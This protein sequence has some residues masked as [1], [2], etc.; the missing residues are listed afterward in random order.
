MI[1]DLLVAAARD[2]DVRDDV[3][4]DELAGFCVNA[5]RSAKQRSKAAVRRLVSVVL[6]GLRPPRPDPPAFSGRTRS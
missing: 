4:A 5:L 1:R 3:P 2:G 6:D